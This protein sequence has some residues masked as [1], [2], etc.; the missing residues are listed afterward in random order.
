MSKTYEAFLLALADSESSRRYDA[1]NTK[2]F[3]G[4]YQ[5]GEEA[6]IDSGY[7]KRDGRISNSFNDG[8]WTGKDSIRS[9]QDFLRSSQ[10]Q[11]NAIRDYMKIQWGYIIFHNLDRYVGQSVNGILITTSGLLA[12]CHLGGHGNLNMF[13]KQGKEFKD[14]Y[15]TR[16]SGYV[17]KFAGYDSPFKPRKKLTAVQKNQKGVATSYQLDTK[18]WVSK[19]TAIQMVKNL[20]L[21]G[22]LVTNSK[23]TVFLRTRPDHTTDNNLIA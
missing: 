19:E 23:G 15:K 17:R 4:K 14:D 2:G 8:Y 3:L 16:I 1:V 22:V 12:G 20:E 10:A 6:L 9:K 21:D 7:Y 18:E 5:M 13:I 11:E